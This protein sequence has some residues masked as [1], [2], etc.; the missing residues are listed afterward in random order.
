MRARTLGVLTL[1]LVLAAVSGCRVDD[2][3]L[4]A[5]SHEGWVIV[6]LSN[7]ECPAIVGKWHREFEVPASGYL[8]TATGP[9]AGYVYERYWLADGSGDRQRLKIGKQVHVRSTTNVQTVSCQV[10][11]SVFWYGDRDH[12][13]GDVSTAIRERVSGCAQAREPSGAQVQVT[14]QSEQG[15]TNEK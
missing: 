3:V 10:I 12:I 14:G 4:A 1:F 7:S 8:C 6:Q 9:T 2:Y 5:G 11:A 13:I 15:G